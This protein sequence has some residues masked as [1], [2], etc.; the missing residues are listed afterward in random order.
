MVLDVLAMTLDIS[1]DN[2]AAASSTLRWWKPKTFGQ[3]GTQDDARS[4]IEIVD[5]APLFRVPEVP[6]PTRHPRWPATVSEQHYPQVREILFGDLK[7]R[8]AIFRTFDTDP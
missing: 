6:H 1:R 8:D 2:G 5:D 4:V 3:T 7:R